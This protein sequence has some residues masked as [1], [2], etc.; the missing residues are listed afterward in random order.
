MKFNQNIYGETSAPIA[1]TD[2]MD[3]Y[4]RRNYALYQLL[5]RPAANIL[6]KI[7][8]AKRQNAWKG[9]YIHGPF[10]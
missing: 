7:N 9:F 8:R 6:K 1:T 4:N 10:R 5:T 3:L 2:L